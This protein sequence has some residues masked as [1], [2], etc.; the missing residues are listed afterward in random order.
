MNLAIRDHQMWRVCLIVPAL[1]GLAACVR[2]DP[3]S[4]RT[5]VMEEIRQQFPTAEIDVTDESELAVRHADGARQVV[6]ISSV[7]DTCRRV[8]RSCGSTVSRLVLM[9]Q[10]AQASRSM[11][12]AVDDVVPILTN[13]TP[14]KS[15][16]RQGN[17]GNIVVHPISEGLGVQFVVF[18]DYL[19]TA[20][21][22]PAMAKLNMTS[23][24]LLKAARKNIETK[25]T[26]NVAPFPGEAGVFQLAGRLVGGGM[27]S[28][29]HSDAVRDRLQCKELALAFPRRG[30][31]LVANAADA[32]AVAR[33]R[34]I[35]GRFLQPASA[36]I[37]PEVY[38]LSGEQ[39]AL[40]RK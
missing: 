35:A 23:D 27:F 36:V 22:E 9:M 19:M 14:A 21:D 7:Q 2:T 25:A 5:F 1:L 13:L 12:I 4:V 32:A 17:P 16:V 29:K 38:L 11:E 24:A 20:V 34:E 28:R 18:S 39:F 3:D 8:P 33:L 30:I 6:D 10:E 37:S 31:V 40:M 26:I 15:T